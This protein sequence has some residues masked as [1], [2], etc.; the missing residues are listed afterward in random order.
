MKMS[1]LSHISLLYFKVDTNLSFYHFDFI[2]GDFTMNE[3]TGKGL[4]TWP[5]RSTY[6]GAVVKG[7]RT[8]HG[9]FKCPSCPSSYTG[10]WYDGKRHGTVSCGGMEERTTSP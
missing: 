2:Q 3:I 10:E 4:Y 7:K 5:D 9:T 1:L 6:E 8:G